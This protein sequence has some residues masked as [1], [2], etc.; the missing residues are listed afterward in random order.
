[1]KAFDH[2]LISLIILD[3]SGCI[4]SRTSSW[5]TCHEQTYVKSRNCHV[6]SHWIERLREKSKLNIFS[7]GQKPTVST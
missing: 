6:L 1:M 7:D 5:D 2:D 4:E 3:V